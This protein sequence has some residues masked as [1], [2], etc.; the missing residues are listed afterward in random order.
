MAVGLKGH[1]GPEL[2]LVDRNGMSGL[3]QPAA[4]RSSLWEED[5]SLGCFG[6]EEPLLR[7]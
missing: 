1:S 2:L 3:V 6:S 5:Q 7:G 4:V